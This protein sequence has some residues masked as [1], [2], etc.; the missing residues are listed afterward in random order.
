[1][2]Q[3]MRRNHFVLD[4]LVVQFYGM[5]G[6]VAAEHEQVLHREL[7]LLAPPDSQACLVQFTLALQ[8]FCVEQVEDFLVVYLEER[9]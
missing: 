8:G 1:M 9:A 6:V 5:L 4:T 3:V 2:V 7:L